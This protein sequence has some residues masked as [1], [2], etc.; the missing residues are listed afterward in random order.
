MLDKNKMTVPYKFIL[1]ISDEVSGK[2]VERKV[3]DFEKIL[4]VPKKK[5]NSELEF[6]NNL[7]GRSFTHVKINAVLN[8]HELDILIRNVVPTMMASK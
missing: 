3:T 1:L 8:I 6:S 5:M 4:I 2:I 7:R